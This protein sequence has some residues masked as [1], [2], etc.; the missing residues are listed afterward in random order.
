MEIFCTDKGLIALG[1]GLA[2]GTI[3]DIDLPL[4]GLNFND[5]SWRI[6][7]KFYFILIRPNPPRHTR[8][9]TILFQVIVSSYNMFCPS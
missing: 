4:R 9:P 8:I 7:L 5:F 6:E 2:N 1:L 3:S